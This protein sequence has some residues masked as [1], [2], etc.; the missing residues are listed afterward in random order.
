METYGKFYGTETEKK[1]TMEYLLY[2]TV[3]DT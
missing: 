2:D 3:S 1:G